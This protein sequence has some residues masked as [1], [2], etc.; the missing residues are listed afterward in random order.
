M[1]HDDAMIVMRKA[2]RRLRAIP[3]HCAVGSVL[4][5]VRRAIHNIENAQSELAKFRES[6]DVRTPPLT[7]ASVDDFVK[8]KEK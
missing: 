5:H 2:I 6:H 3:E 8:L 1:N 4:R 7:P